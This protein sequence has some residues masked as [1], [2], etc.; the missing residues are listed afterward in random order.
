MASTAAPDQNRDV[1][2]VQADPTTLKL[3][4]QVDAWLSAD[5]GLSVLAFV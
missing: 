3:S 2:N 5:I 1:K 4:C